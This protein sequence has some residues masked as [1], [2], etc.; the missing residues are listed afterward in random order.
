MDMTGVWVLVGAVAVAM[1]AGFL[2]R[3]RNGK[4]R[5]ARTSSLPAQ[6]AEL[7]EPSSRV[8]LLQ[9]STEFCAPCKH[10]AVALTTLAKD[11]DGVH[12]V[13]LD[14]TH[15][16]DVAERLGVLS[17]PTTLALTPEGAELFRFSGLPRVDEL[18]DRLASHAR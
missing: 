5:R 6:V 12:H 14:V 2:L 10:A 9:V 11:L 15:Q 18:T 16:P 4:L 3:A 8:T 13:D 17:T 7:I 1:A